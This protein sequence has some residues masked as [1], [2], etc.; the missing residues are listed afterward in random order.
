MLPGAVAAMVRED[1]TAWLGMQ[2]QTRSGDLS[3]DLGSA[4]RWALAAE[5]DSVL[6]AVGPGTASATTGGPAR[7]Q[8][9]L[10]VDA[11]LAVTVHADFGWWLA[12]DDPA[13]ELSAA[14]HGANELIKPTEP[15]TT[16]GVRAAY[17]VQTGSKAHLRWVRPEPEDVLLAALA[18]LR[19]AGQLDLGAGSRYAGTFRAHGLLVPVWDL[20]RERH[21]KE[22]AGP[23]AEFAQRLDA[24]LASV[25]DEPLDDAE[26]RAREVLAGGQITLR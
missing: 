6:T 22:W 12:E 3:N 14:V 23:A 9:L 19:A 24:A 21:A 13:P 15:V 7:L 5:P 1:G 4:L 26:R 18:R 8:D 10:A 25:V 16:E 2:V 17:W 11:E 20:D